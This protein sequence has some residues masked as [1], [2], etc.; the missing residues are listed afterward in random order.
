MGS[1]GKNRALTLLVASSFLLASLCVYSSDDSLSDTLEAVT[2]CPSEEM[3]CQKKS[4][5]EMC[6]DEEEDPL[7]CAEYCNQST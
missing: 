5:L 2:V 3:G 7:D 4:C 1:L 6:L